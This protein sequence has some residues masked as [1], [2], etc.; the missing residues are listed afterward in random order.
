MDRGDTRVVG[1]LWTISWTV[2]TDLTV[3]IT[4]SL[5]KGFTMSG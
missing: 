1:Y 5:L 2:I 3:V 4:A